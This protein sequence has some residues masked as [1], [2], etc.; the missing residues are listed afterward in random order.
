M[1]AITKK[2]KHIIIILALALLAVIGMT[3]AYYTSRNDFKN[4][5]SVAKPGVAVVEEF[6]PADD[7]VPGEEKTKEAWFTNS[8]EIDMLLRFHVDVA[9][10]ADTAPANAKE[11]AEVVTLNRDSAFENNFVSFTENDKV[12]YYYKKVLKPGEATTNVLDSV[13]FSSDLSNDHHGVNYENAQVN[14]IITGETVIASPN[15]D[16]YAEAAEEWNKTARIIS[17][18][19]GINSVEWASKP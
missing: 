15:E 3:I 4:E 19:E 9:W 1:K 2:T 12:Y 17:G 14:I 6:N 7:W 13:T 18:G 16:G 10:E 5:F 8:G 11:A